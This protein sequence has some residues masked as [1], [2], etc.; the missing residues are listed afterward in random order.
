MNQPGDQAREAAPPGPHTRI[1]AEGLIVDGVPFHPFGGEFQYFRVR[2]ADWDGPRTH[3][4]W[5]A[6]L[7]TLRA[8]GLNTISTYIPWDYHAP[9]AGR[10]DWSGPRD[11][12]RFLELAAERGFK[13]IVKPGPFILAEWPHGFGSYGAVPLWW[14]SA[15]KEALVRDRRRKIFHWHPVA[16]LCP[17]LRD[18]LGPGGA[19]IAVQLDNETNLF[20]SDLYRIDW[21][22]DSIR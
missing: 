20:W 9:E 1:T 15:N 19:I 7:D 18:H 6:R 10:Y 4:L 21:H 8:A 17:H 3:E 14:R 5:A 16:A 2:D 12:G 13:L 11:V 22:K